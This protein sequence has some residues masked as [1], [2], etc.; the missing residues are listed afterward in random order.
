MRAQPQPI[1]EQENQL[2]QRVYASPAIADGR[3]YLRGTE[4]LFCIGQR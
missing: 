3:I 4:H 2:G 1:I